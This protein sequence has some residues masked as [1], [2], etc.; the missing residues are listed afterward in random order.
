LKQENPEFNSFAIS[1]SF[2][3]IDWLD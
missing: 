3:P 1:L 2:F